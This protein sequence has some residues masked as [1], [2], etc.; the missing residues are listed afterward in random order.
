MFQG[1]NGLC[2]QVRKE[3]KQKTGRSRRGAGFLLALLFGP[4]DGDNMSRETSLCE[5][6]GVTT[7]KTVLFGYSSS[8]T[9]RWCQA[10][11]KIR[12]VGCDIAC[13]AVKCSNMR[14]YS[15][16]EEQQ[17]MERLPT[18]TARPKR[19]LTLKRQTYSVL[20]RSKFENGIR[21]SKLYTEI[22]LEASLLRHSEK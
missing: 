5:L 2:L 13:S 14:N 7:D 10:M 3:A 17:S 21:R 12:S 11:K 1:R 18:A 6:H 19:L 9:L 8:V 20:N 16:S 4:E 15:S 22:E